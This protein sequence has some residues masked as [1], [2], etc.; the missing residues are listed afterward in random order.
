MQMY[1][2]TPYDRICCDMVRQVKVQHT[3]QILK[4]QKTLHTSP[5][6]VRYGMFFVSILLKMAVIN[7]L[8]PSDDI[9]H[10]GSWSTLVQV[11]AYCLMAPSHHL[12]QCWFIISRV[13]HHSPIDNSTGISK[14]QSHKL[15][16]HV[17]KSKPHSLGHNELRPQTVCMS[18]SCVS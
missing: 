7:S 3:D 16:L 4:P 17:L 5:S 12:T 1:I 6:Q 15:E 13:L 11:M 10:H 14:S 9:W 18:C 2:Y 8:W